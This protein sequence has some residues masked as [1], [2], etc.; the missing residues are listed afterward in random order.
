MEEIKEV[1]I[2]EIVI[3]IEIEKLEINIVIDKGV[4]EEIEIEIEIKGKEEQEEIMDSDITIGE[5]DVESLK[6][7]KNIKKTQ[8]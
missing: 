8:I 1:K 4:E 6:K 2:A 3:E 5:E 7:R